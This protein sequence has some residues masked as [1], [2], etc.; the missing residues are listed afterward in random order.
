MALTAQTGRL[1]ATDARDSGKVLPG[2]GAGC[3]G[4]R[5]YARL[6]AGRGRGRLGGPRAGGRIQARPILYTS[7]MAAQDWARRKKICGEQAST[8]TR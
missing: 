5:S 8:G 1:P 4:A 3:G 2:G 7:A 6:L